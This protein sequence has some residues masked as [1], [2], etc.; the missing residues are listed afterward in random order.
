MASAAARTLEDLFREKFFS[1][2]PKKEG[3][4]LAR[5][6]ETCAQNHRVLFV[7]DGLDEIAKD[8][9]RDDSLALKTFL[10]T[11]L[12]QQH[13]VITSRPS[14][15]DRSLLPTIDLELETIGF[16]PQNVSDFLTKVLEPEA[17]KTVRDF[18]QR[19]PL[20]QGLVNIP[21]QLDVICFS[22]DSLPTD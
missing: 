15:V 2:G 12:A 21:V 22:W 8:T 16:S 14:G 1:Q 3:K 17:V 10:E 19:T 18:I 6:L 5:A 9:R 4:A 20:M 7:L 11:L 13:V